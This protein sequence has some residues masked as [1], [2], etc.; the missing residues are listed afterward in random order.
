MMSSRVSYCPVCEQPGAAVSIKLRADLTRKK[1]K[2]SEIQLLLLL[3]TALVGPMQS[4]AVWV[5]PAR[6]QASILVFDCKASFYIFFENLKVIFRGE[7]KKT[8]IGS[9]S[10]RSSF[11]TQSGGPSFV[12]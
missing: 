8:S 12:E 1:Y 6:L 2:A 3:F 7:C 4:I 9:C 10:K 5:R 11:I